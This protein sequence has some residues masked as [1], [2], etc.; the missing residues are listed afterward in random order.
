VNRPSHLQDRTFDLVVIGGGIIGSG[1]ARD[2]ALRGLSVALFEKNDYCSGTTARSTRLIHGGLRYLET[3]DFRLVR[4]D[5]REREI[6]LNIAPHLVKPLPFIV[7]FY[8][9]NQAYRLKMRLGM[10]LYDLLSFDKAL[11]SHKLLT[12]DGILA[13]APLL[14]T[15]GLQGG[16]LYYDA[17]VA[18]PERLVQENL[19]DARNHGAAACNYSEVVAALRDGK[20]IQGVRV[21]DSI[22]G[23]E[24]R[25]KSRIVI[26]AAGPWLDQVSGRIVPNPDTRARMTKG[27]HIICPPL[28]K[29]ALVLFSRYDGRLFFIIPWLEQSLVGTTDTDYREDPGEAAATADEIRYLVE[30]IRPFVPSMSRDEIRYSYA[31]VRALVPEEGKPSSVSR[32]HRILDEERNGTPGLIS[33]IGGKI[34]GYRAI[35]EEA[36]DVVCDKL[37]IRRGCRTASTPLPGARPHEN[38]GP[39]LSGFPDGKTAQH[40]F[41]VY[42]SRAVEVID[43]G[44][45]ESRLRSPLAPGRPDI[46][47]QV[48]HS[49][50]NEQCVRATDFLLRRTLIGFSP[51]QGISALPAVVSWMAEELHWS[52]SKKSEE[53]DAHVRWAVA[54]RSI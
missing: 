7:P 19:V 1:I 11:P 6:L 31:G 23:A 29:Q 21:R 45:R 30:S 27:I 37:G 35:A 46:A 32:M 38:S 49:V 10:T 9:R 16:F 12:R 2:A 48:V 42:G 40:L 24:I 53:F 25:V 33:I 18:A 20:G 17:Q 14:E 39:A 34:T 22:C 13:A 41:S 15:Q 43:L 51:D 54:S 50:R 28:S 5:L 3:L 44:Q 47:A 26:N 8:G 4:L 52:D 36:V